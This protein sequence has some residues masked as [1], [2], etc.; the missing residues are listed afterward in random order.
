MRRLL[1]FEFIIFSCFILTGCV[2]SKEKKLP[3]TKEEPVVEEDDILS[4]EIKNENEDSLI[5]QLSGKLYVIGKEIYQNGD[6]KNFSKRNDLY[7]VSLQELHEKYSYDISGFIGDD[8]T[9]CDVELSGIYFDPDNSMNIE[10]EEEEDL[11]ISP[12]LIGC[13]KEYSEE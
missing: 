13:S 3:E 11:P 2:H 9:Q 10:H 8:G 1:L 5:F 7:F 6:Y 12:I 4:K